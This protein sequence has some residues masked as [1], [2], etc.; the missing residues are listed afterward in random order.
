MNAR[1]WPV[2]CVMLAVVSAS[3]SGKGK[4]DEESGNAAVAQSTPNPDSQAGMASGPTAEDEA[5][6]LQLDDPAR[7]EQLAR[8]FELMYANMEAAAR[9]QPRDMYDPKAVADSV[10][11]DSKQLLAWVERN[12]Y[13][14][15]YQ[16]SLRGTTGVLMDRLGNS[17]DRALLLAELL[18]VSGHDV[19]LARAR[20]TDDRIS[21]LSAKVRN[22]TTHR[23]RAAVK[24]SAFAPTKLPAE[25]QWVADQVHKTRDQSRR[26]SERHFNE[27]AQRVSAQAPALVAAV[28]QEGGT[29]SA[30]D[31]LRSA[32]RDHWWVQI[33]RDGSWDDLD[34][35]ASETGSGNRIQEADATLAPDKN[36][37]FPLDAEQRHELVIRVVVERWSD[38]SLTEHVV[39]EHALFP[40]DVIG[41]PIFVHHAGSHWSQSWSADREKASGATFYEAALEQREW[42]PVLH[43]GR[44]VAVASVKFTADGEFSSDSL[45]GPTQ[46]AAGSVADVFAGGEAA[47]QGHL[48]AE[49]IDYEIRAPGAPPRKLRHEIFDLLG[50]T[51]R[52]AGQQEIPNV[53]DEQISKRAGALAGA[54]EILPLVSEIPIVFLSE[55]A[56]TQLLTSRDEWINALRTNDPARQ[57]ELMSGAQDEASGLQALYSFAVARRHLSPVHDLVYQD[58]VGLVNLRSYVDFDERGKPVYRSL[59][60]LVTNDV[61]VLPGVSQPWASVAM[62]QGV[63]D[64]A[65]EHVLLGPS[66]GLENVTT[67]FSGAAGRGIET[68]VVR[69][70]SSAAWKK[71]VIA[72]DVRHRVEQD[73]KAGNIVVLPNQVVERRIGWWR[74]NPAT[75]ATVG[76]MDNGFRSDLVEYEDTNPGVQSQAVT[77]RR[78]NPMYDSPRDILKKEFNVPEDHPQYME[79]IDDIIELQT[80]L[81]KAKKDFGIVLE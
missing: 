9:R 72:P 63:A 45:L 36:G 69:D 59:I 56:S 80:K 73:L 18:R 44:R 8:Y 66:I 40:S 39:L 43:V 75:G 21:A 17:L 32:M 67:V 51:A 26:E 50:P 4:N 76:V 64:T 55:V 68:I 1:W 71:L 61:A 38:S 42:L 46:R 19:R 30:T 48:T 65:A 7:R 57:R 74:V 31:R 53:T 22:V 34:P 15:P 49:W 6:A 25:L 81:M 3:C 52:A 79:M 28:G 41:Q 11:R 47:A 77:P 16:G 12:T 14:V 5:E 70:Q 60:D 13:W 62:Q 54:V 27:M 2:A 78:R 23:R 37:K 35:L 20:L 24:E 33:Q 10:G 29:A 58:S